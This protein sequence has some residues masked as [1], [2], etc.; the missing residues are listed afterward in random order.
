[1]MSLGFFDFCANVV[2]VCKVLKMKYGMLMGQPC[3]R[4]SRSQNMVEVNGPVATLTCK[5]AL[6]K[7]GHIL[8]RVWQRPPIKPYALLYQCF[9]RLKKLSQNFRLGGS[10]GIPPFTCL[11]QA[12][13]FLPLFLLLLRPGYPLP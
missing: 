8:P 5:I 9:S 3:L 1:M 10:S 13:N 6:H 11:W 4:W 12:N 2:M 7:C